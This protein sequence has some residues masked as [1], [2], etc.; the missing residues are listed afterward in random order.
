[1]PP[2]TGAS[3]MTEAELDAAV[4]ELAGLL[5]VRV[6]S[7]RN[8]RAGVVTSRGYPDLTLVGPG[9]I[10]FRELKAERKTATREQI[11]WGRAISDAG[12]DWGVWRPG[13][14]TGRVIETELRQ[15]AAAADSN[16]RGADL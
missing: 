11:G 16:G 7:V 10:A 14:L 9:G 2:V 1:M 8:S 13:D 15:L 3:L 6:Y 5:G 12:G 4:R